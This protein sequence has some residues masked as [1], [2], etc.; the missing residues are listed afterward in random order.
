[1]VQGDL[2]RTIAFFLLFVP[3][4]LLADEVYLKDAG[5][6]TGR[7]V[8][9]TD[10]M[11]KVDIGDGILGVPTSR[12]ERIVKGSTPLDEYDERASRL[13]P[14]DAKGWRSLGRWA[15]QQGLSSQSRQAYE[16]VIAIAPDDAEARQAL[17][18]VLLDGRWLTEEES[19]RARGY[20][21]HDGEWMTPAEVQV[22]QA[23]A[24]A[25]QAQ[26]EAERRAND[27]EITALQAEARAREA[28][29]RARE[30][31]DDYG[32]NYPVYWGGWGYGVTY[33]PSTPVGSKR[34][35]NRPVQLPARGRK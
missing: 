1:V 17:G 20:V 29:E 9:Q 15:S 27:A 32:S 2:L 5:T 6:I 26:R 19:Y 12:V 28:E 4:L 16:K 24:A 35:V 31:E 10:T 22:A 8:E 3:T 14:Q 18:Y 25:E 21:K 13:G 11:V 34:P 23:S 30:A 33:W 7:I